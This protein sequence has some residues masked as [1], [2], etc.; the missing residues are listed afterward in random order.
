MLED[1]LHVEVPYLLETVAFLL[2]VVL[3]VPI[4]RRF[5][6]TPIIGFLA[7]G[8]CIGP[9]SFAL[10]KDVEA[11]QHF[12]ELG[13]ILLLF[14]IGLELSFE[15]LRAFS[16]LIFGFGTLHA[17]LCA[18]VI[19]I[20][21]ASWGNSTEASI[22][23]GLC[24]ALS[25]TAVVIQVLTE[26]GELASNYG[27]A[28]FSVL[29]FQDLAVVPILILVSIFG[30]PAGG[31]LSSIILM[32][33]FK[34]A[35][36]VGAIIIFGRYV[37]RYVFRYAAL[38]HAVEVFMAMTI[39][40]ILVTSLLTGVAGL[41]MALGAF[42]AGLLLAETEYRHQ[43]ETD[44]EPFKGIFLGLFFMGVG[45]NLDFVLAFER[46]VWVFLSVIGLL[47]LKS[48]CGFIV[49]LLF[50]IKIKDAIR[51][52]LILAEAGEFAFVVI[53]QASLNYSIIEPEVGQ[54]M[55]VVAGLSMALTPLL[56][57]AGQKIVN[58]MKD[59]DEPISLEDELE[60]K[61]H[62]IIAGFGRVGRAVANVLETQS[63][64]YVG[65]DTN[66]DVVKQASSH[67]EPV[68]LGNAGNTKILEKAGIKNAQSIL[69]TLND[70]K[71]ALNT[72]KSIRQH[73]PAIP[74]IVRAIDHHHSK[75]LL[76]AGATTVVPETFEASLQLAGSVLRASHY[77]REEA[78]ACI[79]L[80]RRHNYQEVSQ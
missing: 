21:A 51:S 33:L 17:G 72:V 23:I 67:G 63:I 75:E 38:T 31:S 58:A 61:D 71:L 42:L 1:L 45:M 20:A 32:A 80:I 76:A 22:I 27:R 24:L 66:A 19:G 35:V 3:V 43:I 55:V 6:V 74:I 77:P 34:A 79:E 56:A 68:F 5:R 60:E 69:V 39:L 16:K 47:A 46:G 15:R 11:V 59:K 41:S 28:S 40:A 70:A 62:V 12:A 65:L 37:L 73:W 14:T 29:L 10:V 26:R 48:V 18:L 30:G 2:T 49:A 25:S 54:F 8:A 7:V 52:A 13:V 64:L 78:D 50:K 44:I 36:A 4:C 57:F 9:H 53:G